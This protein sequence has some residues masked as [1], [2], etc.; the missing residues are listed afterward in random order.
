LGEEAT[1][2]CLESLCSLLFAGFLC[3]GRVRAKASLGLQFSDTLVDVREGFRDCSAERQA[4]ILGADLVLIDEYTAAAFL[5]AQSKTSDF[6][7]VFDDFLLPRQQRDS[8]DCPSGQFDRR[9]LLG[10]L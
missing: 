7:V 8:V 1:G 2:D 3:S 5:N 10:R 6:I 4:S 9:K